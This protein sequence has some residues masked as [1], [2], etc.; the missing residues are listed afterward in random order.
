MELRVDLCVIGGGSGGLSVA[1]GAVQMG[2]ETVLIERDR[3]GG[4]CLNYGC[5]PSKALLAASHDSMEKD[6][7]DLGIRVGEKRVLWEEVGGHVRGVIEGIA[8]HDSEERFTGLGVKVIKGEASFRDGTTVIVG[9]YE[10]KARYFVIATG[11]RPA[12]P[13]ISGLDGVGYL[14]N[15]TFFEHIRPMDLIIIGGGPIGMEMA[16]AHC[17]LGSRV[18]VLERE[19][20]LLRDDE[21]LVGVLRGRLREQGIDIREDVSI[22]S[23]GQGEGGEGIEV[24]LRGGERITGTHILVCTGRTANIERLNL[25]NAGIEADGR[26]VETDERLRTRNKRIFAIGDVGRS[27]RF[28]HIAS[29][30]AGIVIKNVL[31]RIPAKV[32]Y[33]ALPWVTYTSPELAHVG[34]TEREVKEMGKEYRVLRWSFEENDRARTEGETEGMIKVLVK[35]NGQILGVTILGSCAGEM[36]TLWCLAVDQRLKVS[37][38]A[39]M[40]VPYPTLSEVSKRVA[41]SFYTPMLFSD[42]TRSLVRWLKKLG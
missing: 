10:V 15:E 3:M 39:N 22:D 40:V 31:F 8:P 17:G 11:S 28:T 37:A 9:D 12:V 5:V 18:T 41:G 38:I 36:I 6:R 20:I 32:N 26:G 42:R 1:A 33:R 19:K 7:C 25:G 27:P 14:T 21:E 24:C 35:P 30:H 13:R 34:L 29:Y 2:A 4:E 23:V 16:Q